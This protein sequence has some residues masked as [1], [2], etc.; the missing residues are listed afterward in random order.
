MFAG[1]S[2]IGRAM[3]IGVAGSRITNMRPT[4]DDTFIDFCDILSKRSTC[5]RLHT[6]A[7]IV[8]DN[9]VIS[10]GYNGNCSGAEHCSDYW[11]N[12]YSKKYAHQG[13]WD[14]FLTSKFFYDEHHKYAVQNE[15]HGELNAV[16]NAARNN[17]SCEGAT[18]YTLYSPCIECTKLI[19]AS[20]IKRIVFRD[21]Y[22][23]DTAGFEHLKKHVEFKQMVHKST[24]HDPLNTSKMGLLH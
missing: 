20:R 24:Q 17:L 19:I 15:I 22:N 12:E 21:Y 1:P 14:Q 11:Y 8:K 10:I 7:V 16:I 13:T 5:A 4:W 6:A 2:Y 23:R 9:N 3:N 18:M